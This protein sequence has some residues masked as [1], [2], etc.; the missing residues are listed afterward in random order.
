MKTLRE[1]KT[2]QQG[3]G[4]VLRTWTVGLMR[5]RLF[6]AVVCLRPR[7]CTLEPFEYDRL[8]GAEG[9]EDRE[10]TY[11]ETNLQN[12]VTTGSTQTLRSLLN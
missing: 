3:L 12:G 4:P 2:V 8:I 9:M 10:G 5:S 7:I 1:E 6:P 11:G